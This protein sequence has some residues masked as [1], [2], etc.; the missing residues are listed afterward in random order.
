[1]QLLVE[2]IDCFDRCAISQQCVVI[3]VLDSRRR[4]N[5]GGTWIFPIEH[6]ARRMF[7]WR[8]P[9]RNA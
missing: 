4:G 7:T 2:K 3:F 1:M 9:G 8:M 6:T 5:D